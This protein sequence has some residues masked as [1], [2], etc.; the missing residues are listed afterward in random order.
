MKQFPHVTVNFICHICSVPKAALVGSV[1]EIQRTPGN[2]H[3]GTLL[4]FPP[5]SR[6]NHVTLAEKDGLR[7]FFR[8]NILLNSSLHTEALCLVSLRLYRRI[9][10]PV[11]VSPQV[12]SRLFSQKSLDLSF[13]LVR[14]LSDRPDAGLYQFLLGG[15]SQGQKIPY[16][17][18]PH[19][20]RDLLRKQGVHSVRLLKI[21]GH[22]CQQFIDRYADIHCET[23]FP[24]D[25]VLY[26]TGCGDGI[27]VD[28]LRPAHIQKHLVYGK[29]FHGRRVGCADFF[30]RPGTSDIKFKI[31]RHTD[32]L[33]T[34]AQRHGHRFPCLHAVFLRGDRLRNHNSGTLL[35]IS[36]HTGR[37]LPEIGKALFHSFCRFPGK[38]GA[39]YV[40][41]K[42]QPFHNLF[43]P[44]CPDKHTV[45]RRLCS[46]SAPPEIL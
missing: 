20:L 1:F 42:D 21:R 7:L 35:R 28:Q 6:G 13:L 25:P 8:H 46:G 37:D 5:H 3:A 23:Q 15:S 27:R 9:I 39:V 40:H 43:P 44:F 19:L 2:R 32:K 11:G 24:P 16:R 17:E 26:L 31:R 38:K 45:S 4:A 33:R 36:A 22:F 41:M 30:K 14:Q 18:G 34:F 29:R 12:V 10:D